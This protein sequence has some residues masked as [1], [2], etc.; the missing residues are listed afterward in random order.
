MTTRQINFLGLN[1]INLMSDVLSH[2]DSPHIRETKQ[3][4]AYQIRTL[5]TRVVED[6]TYQAYNGRDKV[7]R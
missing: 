4:I 2:F 1:E 5:F 7:E 6:Y 3:R